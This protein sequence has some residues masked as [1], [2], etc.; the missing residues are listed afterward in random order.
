MM[1]TATSV[2]MLFASRIVDGI[3]GGNISLAQTIVADLT[4]GNHSERSKSYGIIGA[5]FG[6]AFITGL[7]ISLF[8]LLAF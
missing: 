8:F 6:L 3:L 5:L 4:E 1:G 2:L 7:Y